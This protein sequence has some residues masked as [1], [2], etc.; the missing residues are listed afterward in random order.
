MI[1]IVEN[2]SIKTKSTVYSLVN[3]RNDVFSNKTRKFYG[4]FLVIYDVADYRNSGR[5]SCYKRFSVYN[6]QYAIREKSYGYENCCGRIQVADFM[7]LFTNNVACN[8]AKGH[9]CSGKGVKRCKRQ[10]KTDD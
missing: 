2:E 8:H 3:H 7:V 9:C 1:H 6:L 5:T 10:K 4:V